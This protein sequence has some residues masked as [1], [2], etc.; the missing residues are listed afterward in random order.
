MRYA[1]LLLVLTA[2]AGC[3]DDGFTPPPVV[4]PLV[5]TL[6]V[7]KSGD[8]RGILRTLP[9]GV[10]CDVDCDTASFDYEDTEAIDV[11]AELS[12][13]AN[14]G[15]LVCTSAGDELSIDALDDNGDAT[16]PLPLIVDGV[17]L[18]WSCGG[19]FILV[20]TLQVVATSGTGSGRVRGSLSSVIGADEPKRIDCASTETCVAAYFDA[21]EE[22]LTATAD[23][24]SVF[25]GWEFCAG[26]AD[27]AAIALSMTDDEN[28]RPVFDLQ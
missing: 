25:A 1:A 8:G 13:N 2:L 9:A 27:T 20:H 4:E 18:D 17:G 24:G 15:G 10:I 14:F 23:Q 5:S 16:L 28:C 11:V 26:N 19:T 21:E 3:D 7:S 6:T 22:T 12:R